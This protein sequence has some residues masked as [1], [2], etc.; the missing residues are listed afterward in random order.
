MA[1]KYFGYTPKIIQTYNSFKFMHFKNTKKIH[2]INKLC[3]EVGITHQLIRPKTSKHNGKVKR[4][5]R[6]DNKEFYKKLSF[7]SY[8]D[9]K[10]KI[11]RYLHKSKTLP[12]QTLNLLNPMEKNN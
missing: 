11:K 2:P 5:H 1:I 10:N 4:S 9:L 12:I 7:Y 8:D 6:N 3:N